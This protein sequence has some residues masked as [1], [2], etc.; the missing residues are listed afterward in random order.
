MHARKGAIKSYDESNFG[1]ETVRIQGSERHIKRVR[2]SE[3]A[4]SPE[5]LRFLS[6]LER[7]GV[8]VSGHYRTLGS[9]PV[10]LPSIEYHP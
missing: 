1:H 3:Q 10:T 8:D 5:S 6:Q 9:G 2:I 7:Y 4:Y